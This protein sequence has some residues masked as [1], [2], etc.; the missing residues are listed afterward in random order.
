[1]GALIPGAEVTA[2]NVNTGIVTVQISNETGG[3]LFASL[4][5]GA[6]RV[7]AVLP[8]FRPQTYQNVQLSQG[9]QIR[10]NFKLEVAALGTAIEVITDA[11]TILAT[12]S[13]SVGRMLPE[14]EVRNLPLA[15]RDVLAVISG[16]GAV[17][18]NVGGQDIRALNIVRD[19]LIINDTRYGVGNQAAGQNATF[20]SPDLVEEVQIVT[21]NVDAESGR[22]SAQIALQTRSGTNE[23]HGALFYMNN[24]SALSSQSWFDNL[25]EHRSFTR[26]EANMGVALPVR[27]FGTKLSFSSSS[28]TNVSLRSLR[29][30]TLPRLSS[31]RRRVR[32]FS[33]ILPDSE[34][35]MRYRRLLRST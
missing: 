22:G 27:S 4:Q 12:T 2:T 20:V 11:D 34:T 3:Y 25:E 1:M 15:V 7:S 10:L 9:Q 21:G 32:E 35:P 19:G 16:M 26:T 18:R 17:D 23:F 14:V 24:N 31:R 5:P 13:A 8:G 30:K 6:Y 28:I 33:D 29:S